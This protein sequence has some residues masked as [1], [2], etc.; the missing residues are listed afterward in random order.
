MSDH[1]LRFIPDDPHFVPT[2]TAQERAQAY[3]LTL[4]PD[5]DFAASTDPIIAFWD[6]G[7]N[8]ER[9]ACPACGGELD[10]DAWGQLMNDDWSDEQGFTMRSFA[11]PCCGAQH[12]LHDL[13]YEP[14]QGF[15]RF[16]LSAMNANIGELSADQHTELER[17]LGCPVRVI[18]QHI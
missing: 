7:E 4:A 8:M 13:R 15:G 16:A 5:A 17:L 14:A 1:W 3:L 2:S 11:L 12:T 6:C 18:D 10:L 9:V